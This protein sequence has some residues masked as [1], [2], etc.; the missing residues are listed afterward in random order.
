MAE[1]YS[2]HVQRADMVTWKHPFHRDLPNLYVAIDQDNDPRTSKDRVTETHVVKRNLAPTWDLPLVFPPTI[3]GTTGIVLRLYHESSFPLAKDPCLGELKTTIDELLKL[4]G[5]DGVAKLDLTSKGK[6][7]ARLLVGMQRSSLGQVVQNMAA[8]SEVLREV[9]EFKKAVT[10]LTRD[11]LDL[12]LPLE[13]VIQKLDF[14]IKIGDEIAKIHPYANIAWKILTLV[15]TTAKK[16]QEMDEKVIKLVETMAEVYSFVDDVQF[17]SDK[18]K[19]L[20]QT[21]LDI[22]KETVECAMFIHEYTAHAFSGRAVHH[23]WSDTSERIDVLSAVLIELKD[24][25]DRGVNIQTAFVSV[26]LLIKLEKLKTLNPVVFNAAVRPEC[27]PGTRQGIL[28]AINEWLATPSDSHNVL[29]LHGVYGAGKSTI[30]TSVSQYFRGLHRLGAFIFFERDNPER[31]SPHTVISTIAYGLAKSN[32]HILT[33]ICAAIETETTLVDAPI[34]TQF[35]KLLLEPLLH[36][37][38]HVCGPVIIILDALDECGDRDSRRGLVSLITEEFHKL[39]GAYRFLITSRPDSDIARRFHAQTRITPMQLDITTP[40]TKHDILAYI[41]H[42][43]N[44]IQRDHSESLGL[45]WPGEPTIEKLADYAGGLFIWASTAIKFIGE[46]DPGYRLRVLFDSGHDLEG[47]VDNLYTIALR[48]CAPWN[49]KSFSQDA[50]SVLGSI[51]FSRV[52]LTAETIDELLSFGKG[53]SSEVLGYLGCVIQWSRDQPDQPARLLHAS[54]SDYLTDPNRSSSNPWAIISRIHSKAL[55]LRCLR[56]LNHELRFNICGLE[57]SRILNKD[58]EKLSDSIA[59][60]ISPHLMYAAQFWTDHLQEADPDQETLSELK[61]LMENHFLYWLEVLSLREHISIATRSLNIARKYALEA[62]NVALENLI[63]DTA[64]F[65][66]TF[67][68]VIAQSVPHIYISALP[69]APRTSGIQRQ[70]APSFPNTLCCHGTLAENWPSIQKELRG[71]T[72]SVEVVAF[73]PDGNQIVSGSGDGT[74]RLWDS[75]TGV[76]AEEFPGYSVIVSPNSKW[77]LFGSPGGITRVWDLEN[78]SLAAGEFHRQGWGTSAVSPDRKQIVTLDSYSVRLWDLETGEVAGV[79]K[80][81]RNHV[82]CVAFSPDGKDIVSGSDDMTVRVWDS[83]T[84]L[85]TG[86]FDG[87]NGEVT[88]VAFSSSGKQIVSG[89][90]DGK[91]RILDFERRVAVVVPP[92]FLEHTEHV[93]SVAFS[94]DGQRIV[95]GSRRNRVH[96]W[97]SQTGS[98]V[99]GP[100]SHT[101]P[102]HT[103]DIRSITFSSDG[104]HIVSGSS[105]T[106]IC[107][108][109]SETG[110]LTDRFEGHTDRVTSVAFSPDSKWIVSGS[111]DKTVRVWDSN[112]GV[113]AAT[114]ECGT[115]VNS[116]AFSPDGKLIV[117]GLRDCTLRIWNSETGTVAGNFEGHTDNVNS[118]AFSP[119]GQH[120]ASGSE[121]GTV[122]VW[123]SRSGV[124]VLVFKEHRYSVPCVSFSPDG[125]HIASVYDKTVHVWDPSTGVVIASL[126]VTRQVDSVA[127][128][129]D[130]RQLVVGHYHAGPEEGVYDYRN[131]MLHVWDWVE[132]AVIG[133]H[134][135]AVTSVAFSPDGKKV[136]SGGCDQTVRIWNAKTGAVVAGPLRGHT[137]YVASVAFSPDGKRIV[138]GSWDC[139]IR[140]W[141]TDTAAVVLEES[142]GGT[143]D[144]YT[145]IAFSPDGGRILSTRTLTRQRKSTVSIWDSETGGLVAGPFSASG[146][147]DV[148]FSQ[149]GKGL[150]ISREKCNTTEVWDAETG[151][152]IAGPYTP[153]TELDNTVSL[154]PDAERLVFG[155]VNGTVRVC[156][157]KT[158]ALVAGPFA[159]GS[160]LSKPVVS[161]VFCPDGKHIVITPGEA[162]MHT[163]GPRQL[164]NSETGAVLTAP[165]GNE[166]YAAGSSDGKVFAFRTANGLGIWNSENGSI[167]RIK[168][169]CWTV[170]VSP[171]GRQ[172]ATASWSDMQVFVW[173]AQTGDLVVQYTIPV[174]INRLV[175]SPDGMRIAFGLWDG[176]IRIWKVQTPDLWGSPRFSEAWLMNSSSERILWVPPA[177]RKRLCL[178]WY[179]VTISSQTTTGLDLTNF[180]HGTEWQQC[181]D[182]KFRDA[183]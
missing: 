28:L 79:F 33:A 138:S 100:F 181:I 52:P 155:S 157:S 54:F 38:E 112:S 116:V 118:V 110:A 89:S 22:A 142:E 173:S 37:Q 178:P 98:V 80:G 148:A 127:F 160:R 27:L 99:A 165:F 163:R 104:K 136:V 36:S 124:V 91:V 180:V 123:E 20:E 161:V 93:T 92:P 10:E 159:T 139:T 111:W 105:D 29:W 169:D 30:S 42:S 17:V 106:T 12:D 24:N 131:T 172:V 68:P 50:V 121:D 76:L 149:N 62:E 174:P 46:Y 11:R 64:K 18:L 168:T 59:V 26:Q 134:M 7:S 19:R 101:G 130:G 85:L 69:F 176:T 1:T 102:T 84:G 25:F 95:T 162:L 66:A 117:S 55:A 87:Y 145:S 128:S 40:S 182:P 34:R 5:D 175:F 153:Q 82:R 96:I 49:N 53:K 108:R 73:S 120:I 179:H 70:F 133:G 170:A 114:F 45:T 31:S 15:Y 60:H 154:S 35:E 150:I 43:L 48:N 122:R 152:L 21:V 94:P 146:I 75:E 158:L 126:V 144:L 23:T 41:R 77:I 125:K 143:D 97:S 115:R 72:K 44:E 58:V 135:G 83:A 177:L 81:H 47:E 171:D 16:Q 71:H 13:A 88:S 113:V 109:D 167:T 166:S 107:V 156:D 78:G 164:L 129:P 183:R 140:V 32:P 103:G 67:A 51:V 147:V 141:D 56:V 3:T 151:S 132:A 74:I 137:K 119:D 86:Y 9:N 14:I 61:K 39:P 65:V 90:Q 2:L 63:Q 4:Q 8:E 6:I 57:D